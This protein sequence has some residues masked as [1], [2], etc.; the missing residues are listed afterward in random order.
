M[1]KSIFITATGT[2][3]GKT[4]ISAQILR[5]M[6]KAGKNIGYF[7]PALSGADANGETDLS[8]A[9]R[10]GENVGS[11]KIPAACPFMYKTAV[12]PH[13]AGQLENNPVDLEV[14]KKAYKN[15]VQKC[16]Y[17]VIEGAGG[18]VCPITYKN[19]K[20]IMLSDIAETLF[21][22]IRP[23]T[24][25]VASCK[26]GT[27]NATYLTA[28][29][30]KVKKFDVKGIVINQYQSGI[31]E[32]DNVKQLERLT[33]LPVLDKVAEGGELN[34]KAHELIKLWQ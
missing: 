16:D 27:I 29:F 20:L 32:D 8:Y 5:A 26:L 14:V 28:V 19:D 23:K 3:I 13:L 7:K 4:Y 21:A 30:L 9:V 24:I 15:I 31:M 18:A 12:S 1:N 34:I 22:P 10:V 2:E 6:R 33:G 25:I 17:V 11:S